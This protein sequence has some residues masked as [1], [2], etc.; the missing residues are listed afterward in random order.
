MEIRK[1]VAIAAALVVGVQVGAA[2]QERHRMHEAEEMHAAG[3]ANH[4]PEMFLEHVRQMEDL[5]PG[6]LMVIEESVRADGRAETRM[7]VGGRRPGVPRCGLHAAPRARGDSRRLV[8]DP[9][10]LHES[11]GGD[12]TRQA[13]PEIRVVAA[14]GRFRRVTHRPS[15]HRRE[16][17]M[18]TRTKT[19]LVTGHVLPV[20]GGFVTGRA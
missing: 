10:Q 14:R 7:G 2:S 18:S 1:S 5:T 6:N 8:E 16:N 20:D 11:R 12:A 13:I 19:A 3:E 15:T 4:G 9:E 17:D